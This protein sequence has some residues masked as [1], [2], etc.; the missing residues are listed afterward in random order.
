MLADRCDVVI[1]VDTHK[2]SHA[3]AVVQA[4]SGSV[5]LEVELPANRR[6]YRMALA[7]VRRC[8]VGRRVWALEGTG[9]YGAGL[10]RFLQARAE[11]VRE[12]ERPRRDCRQGRLKSDPL[13]A[14]AAAR[15]LLASERDAERVR[16]VGAKRCACC[17]SRARARSPSGALV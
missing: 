10:A 12:V 11:Q 16:A 13:D 8:A 1:G 15:S 9:S 7:A 17:S 5:L 6:G 2:D 14:L 3:F 4:W